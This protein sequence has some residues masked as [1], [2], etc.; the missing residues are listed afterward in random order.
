MTSTDTPR[1]DGALAALARSCYRRRR[2]VLLAWIVGVIAVAFVGFGYGAASNNDYSG[3]GSG[4]ARTR[5]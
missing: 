3:E 4:S 2:L 1:T 5:L